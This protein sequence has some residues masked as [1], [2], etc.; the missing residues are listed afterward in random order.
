MTDFSHSCLSEEPPQCHPLQPLKGAVR[1]ETETN[2]ATGE[3]SSTSS[4]HECSQHPSD[5]EPEMRPHTPGAILSQKEAPEHHTVDRHGALS[6]PYL[7]PE[8]RSGQHPT[9][10]SDLWGLGCLSYHL[11]CGTQSVYKTMIECHS[12]LTDGDVCSHCNL[13][14]CLILLLCSFVCWRWLWYILLLLTV[15]SDIHTPHT[16]THAH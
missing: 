1:E 8:C 15:D 3:S 2:R 12:G 14:W 7:A 4:V 16:D 6:A 9:E 13:L 11:Y 10:R 5:S